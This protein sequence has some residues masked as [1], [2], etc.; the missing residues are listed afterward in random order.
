M[1]AATR[2]G[3]APTVYSACSAHSPAFHSIYLNACRY[4]PTAA[5]LDSCHPTLPTSS[6][7]DDVYLNLPSSCLTR[8]VPSTPPPSPSCSASGEHR[9]SQRPST[10]LMTCCA[11]LLTTYLTLLLDVRNR[12]ADLDAA[13]TAWRWA[14]RMVWTEVGCI[15]TFVA[16]ETRFVTHP[17]LT[18]WRVTTA[19]N[20]DAGF[21][22]R[23]LHHTHL[24]TPD[25]SCSTALPHAPHH[26]LNLAENTRRAAST[27]YLLHHYRPALQRPGRVPYAMPP[28][29]YAGRY[30]LLRAHA[31]LR[32][33]RLAANI[34]LTTC[35][36][37]LR[38]VVAVPT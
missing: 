18:T 10:A 24:P 27:A 34:P 23:R 28:W 25:R 36:Q 5:R 7:M 38:A 37:R 20:E 13:F 1:R 32:R 29:P 3:F 9:H 14:Y 15:M 4:S 30:G 26:V 2:A 6:L 21:S 35:L 31:V 33:H 19:T 16:P 12:D 22:L 8:C 11:G 17:I